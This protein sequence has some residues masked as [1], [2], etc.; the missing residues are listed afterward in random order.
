[1]TIYITD[2]GFD[3]LIYYCK[4]L[5]NPSTLKYYGINPY[6]KITNEEL[7]RI[8]LQGEPF[9]PTVNLINYCH[10]SLNIDR[11]SPHTN[12]IRIPC[13][14][15][16]IEKLIEQHPEIE[17]LNINRNKYTSSLKKIEKFASTQAY[18]F[19]YDLWK[20]KPGKADLEV[21]SLMY[22]CS[23]LKKPVSEKYLISLYDLSLDNVNVFQFLKTKLGT[24]N[25][26]K[27]LISFSNSDLWKIFVGSEYKTPLITYVYPSNRQ[28]T[29]LLYNSLDIVKQKIIHSS[30]N[31]KTAFFI[32]HTWLCNVLTQQKCNLNTIGS[33]DIQTADLN[34]LLKI[35]N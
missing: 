31:I 25:G 32:W 9:D 26:L 15:L 4:N 33:F 30:L 24:L 13:I 34:N 22:Y 8:L 23:V 3:L 2:A 35:L 17:K 29:D 18:K 12:Y 1:M 20:D 5:Y 21:F 16:K 27:E 6:I 19:M 11:F 14:T 7:T 10:K 28:E